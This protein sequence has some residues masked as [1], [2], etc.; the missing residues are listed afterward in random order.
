V[1]GKVSVFCPHC[2]SRLAFQVGNN[3]ILSIS[4]EGKPSHEFEKGTRV[5][6][7]LE[8]M[9]FE[10]VK[11]D[12]REKDLQYQYVLDKQKLYQEW[13]YEMKRLWNIACYELGLQTAAQQ[14]VQADDGDSLSS[15][16]VSKPNFLSTLAAFFNPTHRR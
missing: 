11:R 10:I 14:S 13:E 4:C 7:I 8:G 15:Q 1:K 9:Y 5:F 6:E 16:A 2:Q 12:Q 3:E